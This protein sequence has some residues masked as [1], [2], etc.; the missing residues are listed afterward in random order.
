MATLIHLTPSIA[1]PRL[2][3]QPPKKSG[4][5]K[6]PAPAPG[7]AGKQTKQVKNPLFESRPKNFGIGALPSLYL[8]SDSLAYG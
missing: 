3:D 4:T 8:S 6:K 5:G 1:D 7:G 2:N